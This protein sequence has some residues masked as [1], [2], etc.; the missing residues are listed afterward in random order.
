MISEANYLSMSLY[1]SC[2]DSSSTTLEKDS[3][4]DKCMNSDLRLISSYSWARTKGVISFLF[5]IL[6][7]YLLA[8]CTLSSLL[9]R[10]GDSRSTIDLFI[11]S[12]VPGLFEKV[13]DSLCFFLFSR[14]DCLGESLNS[15]SVC[16]ISK[17]LVLRWLLAFLWLFI[18]GMFICF[19]TSSSLVEWRIEAGDCLYLRIFCR[20]KNIDNKINRAKVIKLWVDPLKKLLFKS[21]GY[22]ITV[23]L[24]LS[25][26]DTQ[27]LWER[28][29]SPFLFYLW[30][31][32]WL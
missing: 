11:D 19:S 18:S 25:D 9:E 30:S 14:C 16:W 17:F 6:S 5:P 32:R 31:S 12:L 29:L 10:S 15:L 13:S 1:R 28:W 7:L 2:I 8:A 23:C 26:L 21:F 27:W 3:P 24:T 20:S 4:C 22:E